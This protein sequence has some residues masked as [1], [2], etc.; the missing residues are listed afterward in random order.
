MYFWKPQRVCQICS[1]PSLL[2]LDMTVL[3]PQ[4]PTSPRVSCWHLWPCVAPAVA[5]LLR[6]TWCPMVFQACV[7]LCLRPTASYFSPGLQQ[8]HLEPHL[9]PTLQGPSPNP[10]PRL[11]PSGK[12]LQRKAWDSSTDLTK[13]PFRL[14][15]F[16]MGVQFRSEDK[17]Y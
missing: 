1:Q 15:I 3:T 2:P 6:Q 17:N 14:K 8:L 13:S 9:L 7:E 12:H 4:P 5:P 16:P 10:L 11:F